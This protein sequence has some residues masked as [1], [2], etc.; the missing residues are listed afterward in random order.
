M[1]RDFSPFPAINFHLTNTSHSVGKLL[2]HALKHPREAR[3]KVL[4][5]NSFTATPH[6]ILQEFEAQTGG[7]KWFVTYTSLPVLRQLEEKAWKENN[8]SAA[9]Y[10]LRRIWT[11]GGTL[12]ATRDN[13]IIGAEKTDTLQIAVAKAIVAAAKM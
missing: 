7:E 6:Q 10:T 11:E 4:K 2:I 13:E 5:V 3:N 9:V 8:P 12:Y 1:S